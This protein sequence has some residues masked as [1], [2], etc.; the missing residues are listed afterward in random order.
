[1]E[2]ILITNICY[3]SC[4]IS[5]FIFND[6]KT[7][8]FLQLIGCELETMAPLYVKHFGH[9]FFSVVEIPC[10]FQNGEVTEESPGLFQYQTSAYTL[11]PL[12]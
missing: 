7:L 8:A 3:S 1:M 4:V 10:L 11:F 5:S 9:T 6:W 2:K 12:Y